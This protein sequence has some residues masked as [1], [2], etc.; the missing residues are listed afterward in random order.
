MTKKYSVRFESQAKKALKKM[1]KPTAAMIMSWIKS[2]L[3][4]CND[5]YLY[6]KSLVGNHKGKWR[7]RVGNYRLIANINDDELVILILTAGH[8]KE[9]Y[10]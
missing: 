8:R 6:G 3:V 4:G 7:Y 5:P 9:I 1:D 10:K 2:H